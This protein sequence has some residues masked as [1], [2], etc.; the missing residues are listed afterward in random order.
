[1]FKRTGII[2]ALLSATSG[3]MTAPAA[4]AGERFRMVNERQDRREHHRIHRHGR[5]HARADT[6]RR[7]RWKRHDRNSYSGIVSVYHRRH[8]GTWSFATLRGPVESIDNMRVVPSA[9]IIDV[10]KMAPNSGCSMENGVCVIR[11]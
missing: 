1:M 2:L 10:S 8:V 4:F 7:H 9:K 6:E 3:L 11:P 5:D